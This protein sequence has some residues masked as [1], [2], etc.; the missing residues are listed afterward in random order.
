MLQEQV[1][2]AAGTFPCYRIDIDLV[3]DPDAT[4][5]ILWLSDGVGLVK[6]YYFDIDGY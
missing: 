3:S 4:V 5:Q 1:T 6:E 2:T